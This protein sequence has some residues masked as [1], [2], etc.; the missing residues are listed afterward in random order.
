MKTDAPN[1]WEATSGA[2]TIGEY[3]VCFDRSHGFDETVTSVLKINEDGSQTLLISLKGSQA[4]TL[5]DLIAAARAETVREKGHNYCDRHYD[6]IC[7]CCSICAPHD[8]CEWKEKKECPKCGNP[9]R[10]RGLA[11]ACEQPCPRPAGGTDEP[12]V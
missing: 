6:S 7:N 2:E 5:I 9:L 12:K 1:G 8:S 10:D 11:T 3:R 4:E